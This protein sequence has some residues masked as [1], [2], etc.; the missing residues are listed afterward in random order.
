MT[1]RPLTSL[2]KGAEVDDRSEIYYEIAL[3]TPLGAVD[4]AT[5]GFKHS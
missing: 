5:Q 4:G 2:P 3:I 1:S